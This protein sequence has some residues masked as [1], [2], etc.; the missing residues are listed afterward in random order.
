[1][2][3]TPPAEVE[4]AFFAANHWG[5]LVFLAV[6]AL[7]AA[8]SAVR[9][10]GRGETTSYEGTLGAL[11]ALQVSPR[12]ASYRVTLE[13]D[14]GE[15]I[16]L[17][18]LNQGRVLPYLQSAPTGQRVQVEARDGIVRSLTVR[19]RDVT[20]SERQAPLLLLLAAVLLPGLLLTA[21]ALPAVQA[22]RA[23][24]ESPRALRGEEEE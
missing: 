20:I 8:G 1:M 12:G 3:R 16:S 17:R 13:R 24:P 2:E 4:P 18:L 11:E 5:C 14:G 10:L 22:R 9:L 23:Q 19:E 7:V 6:L 21:F 15:V